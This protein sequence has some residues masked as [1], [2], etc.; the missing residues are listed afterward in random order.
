[1]DGI[2]LVMK[3]IQAETPQTSHRDMSVEYNEEEIG[4]LID[5][6]TCGYDFGRKSYYGVAI[7]SNRPR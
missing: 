2:K 7:P 1:M 3:D 4:D 6:H 5:E